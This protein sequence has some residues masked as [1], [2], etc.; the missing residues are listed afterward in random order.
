MKFKK[1][2]REVIEK[3]VIFEETIYEN[4]R[5]WEKASNNIGKNSAN[6][7]H[8]KY[9]ENYS[10]VY[11]SIITENENTKRSSQK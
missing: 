1:D 3:A 6:P 11:D 9:K 7:K 10:K 4:L 2:R 8:C 5:N